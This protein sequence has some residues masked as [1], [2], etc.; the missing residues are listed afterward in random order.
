MAQNTPKYKT[1]LFKGARGIH[2][3]W[4]VNR[5][6]PGQAEPQQGGHHGVT[7]VFAR[8]GQRHLI[9]QL[10]SSHRVLEVT[11]E[12][13]SGSCRDPLWDPATL[14]EQEDRRGVFASTF[15]RHLTE[16][17]RQHRFSF[18]AWPWKFYRIQNIGTDP[19]K[20]AGVKT[21]V[22]QMLSSNLASTLPSFLERPLRSL[23][24]VECY[25]YC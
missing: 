11:K 8:H 14:S 1:S 13:F 5:Q 22:L 20:A 17:R 18:Y 16:Q 4:W 2:R 6:Q 3:E 15:G 21:Y 12:I 9:R 10:G 25:C 24:T 7:F 19:A 23:D